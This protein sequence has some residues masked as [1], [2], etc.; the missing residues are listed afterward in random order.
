MVARTS[1]MGYAGAEGAGEGGSGAEC[2]GVGEACWWWKLELGESAGL[3]LG[4][5]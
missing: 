2:E 3:A 4:L 1:S 5:G